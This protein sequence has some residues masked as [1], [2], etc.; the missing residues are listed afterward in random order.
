MKINFKEVKKSKGCKSCGTKHSTMPSVPL[1]R[2]PLCG[3]KKCEIEEEH[4]CEDYNEEV[5]D[6]S[7]IRYRTDCFDT[8]KMKFFGIEKGARL[9]YILEELY[10]KIKDIEYV[11]TPRVPNKPN[12]NSYQAIIADLYG[13]L[14]QQNEEIKILK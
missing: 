10:T 11:S 3:S 4:E 14:E 9:D 12:L 8:S 1:D 13:M 5:Y 2:S 6:A 7:Q